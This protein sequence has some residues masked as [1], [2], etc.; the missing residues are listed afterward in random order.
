M[1]A[2]CS[3]SMG[4]FCQSD[5]GALQ[6]KLQE[7]FQ[8]LAFPIWLKSCLKIFLGKC[9]NSILGL[10]NLIPESTASVEKMRPVAGYSNYQVLAPSS[11]QQLS[12]RLAM[13][14]TLHR[15]ENWL[16]GSGLCHVSTQPA[17]SH[18]LAVS[19]DEPITIF[20]DK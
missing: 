16:H 2:D 1:R 12:P 18:G 5:L 6:P 14:V 19:V 4:L 10:Q 7:R 15:A 13:A 8:K 17:A 11:Q 3:P 20:A 9:V